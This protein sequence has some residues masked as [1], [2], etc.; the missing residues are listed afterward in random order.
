MISQQF[1][2]LQN[3]RFVYSICKNE[4]ARYLVS[5]VDICGLGL[6]LICWRNL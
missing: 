3:L 6:P 5:I 1:F 2:S 4:G